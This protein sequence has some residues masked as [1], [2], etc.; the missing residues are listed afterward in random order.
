MILKIALALSGL[1]LE[2]YLKRKLITYIP[3]DLYHRSIQYLLL[4]PFDATFW[5]FSLVT[6]LF[7][8]ISIELQ[9]ILHTDGLIYS[10]HNYCF[11]SNDYSNSVNSHFS[12]SQAKCTIEHH[13]N[14]SFTLNLIKL[15]VTKEDSKYY[16]KNSSNGYVNNFSDNSFSCLRWNSNTHQFLSYRDHGILR[17]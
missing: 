3:D 6:L 8:V 11:Y 16:L 4:L 15:F 9:N 10:Y 2:F 12:H 13:F 14:I 17:S 1:K 5:S 7:N